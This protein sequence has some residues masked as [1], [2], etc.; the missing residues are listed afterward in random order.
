MLYFNLFLYHGPS[1]II[2]KIIPTA[3]HGGMQV[4]GWV[5]GCQLEERKLNEIIMLKNY[6]DKPGHATQFNLL[7][8][9]RVIGYPDGQIRN[10]CGAISVKVS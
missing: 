5:G 7:T 8:F 3:L 4:V 10:M 2:Q 1:G 6:F 9:Y